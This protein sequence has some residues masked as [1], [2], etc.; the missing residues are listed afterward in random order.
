MGTFIP[1]RSH[2][3]SANLVVRNRSAQAELV[4]KTTNQT[5]KICPTLIVLT[6]SSISANT[7]S[8]N[9]MSR[10][11]RL[12]RIYL[13]A[14]RCLPFF[15]AVTGPGMENITPGFEGHKEGRIGVDHRP[16]R[17]RMPSA[18]LTLGSAFGETSRAS[19]SMS[20]I[21]FRGRLPALVTVKA[22]D[23]LSVTAKVWPGLS[24]LTKPAEWKN[25]RA[26]SVFMR[27]V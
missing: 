3:D 10:P 26:V 8:R 19:R 16:L 25:S 24:D 11:R 12:S 13:A 2:Y 21:V 22:G 7:K 18:K 6:L 1:T 20:A 14:G 23:P 5:P 15:M 17:A 9:I 27:L 4:Q